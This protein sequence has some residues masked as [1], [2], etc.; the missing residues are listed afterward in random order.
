MSAPYRNML[1]LL[2]QLVACPN[3]ETFLSTAL[4]GF[5]QLVP[6][7]QAGSAFLRDEQGFRFVAFR[8]YNFS[9]TS[10]V[11]YSLEKQL[12][13]YGGSLDEALQGIA[14]TSAVKVEM[15]EILADPRNNRPIQWAMTLPIPFDGRIEAWLHL[16]RFEPEPF[17]EESHELAQ[18][19]AQS[20]EVVLRALRERE[21]TQAR[22]ERE[23]MMAQILADMTGYA[24]ELEVWQHLPNLVAKLTKTERVFALKRD[25]N[26]L[27]LLS[28]VGLS[29]ALAERIPRGSGIS[30][31][32]VETKQVHFTSLDDPEIWVLPGFIPDAKAFGAFV[33]IYDQDNEAQGSLNIFSHVAF[34][35]EDKSLLEVLGHTIGQAL[36]R[37]KTQEREVERLEKLSRAGE[38]LTLAQTTD[39]LLQT[40]V[41]E[42]L[43]QTRASCC[44]LLLHRDRQLE[45][46]G[47]KGGQAAQL[48][49]HRVVAG[50]GL[51]W[52]VFESGKALHLADASQKPEAIYSGP[53]L[54][55][56][57]LGVPLFGPEGERLGVLSVDTS[58]GGGEIAPQDRYTLEA[59][60]KLAGIALSRLQAISHA[61]RQTDNYRALV[62]MSS[63]LEL[64]T[65]PME[66]ASKSL[67]SL[68]GLLDLDA[69]ALYQLRGMPGREYLEVAEFFPSPSPFDVSV[70]SRLPL[71]EGSN[72][73]RRML[74]ERKVVVIEDYASWSAALPGLVDIGLGTLLAFPLWRNER[75]DGMLALA[76]FNRTIEVSEESK[77]LLEAVTRRLERALERVQH[78]QEI[79]HSR[80][81]ALRT[82]GLGLEARDFE[83]KGHTDRVVDLVAELGQRL[84]F[85]DIEGLR[86]GA[87]L[88]DLGKMAISDN[89]LL[90]PGPLSPE[91]WEI[92]KRH[93]DL[94]AQMIE[95]FVFLPQTAHNIVRFHHERLDGSGYPLGLSYEAI[96]L[97]ARIFAVV[98]VFDALM[99]A[100]PYK[101]AWTLKETHQELRRQA[102]FTLDPDV[103]EAMLGLTEQPEMVMG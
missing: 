86:M 98:D 41:E 16:D 90:K 83:T 36:S 38:R 99:H 95:E 70:L 8:N 103:V 81:D 63:E 64:I 53:R 3:M 94:G 56:A 87:Y 18:E 92:M 51:S 62:Q 52:Q 67:Q 34:S 13:W 57:Y 65:D 20:L 35:L 10:T 77:A 47:A 101:R 23:A 29:E 32:A 61:Y 93:C 6:D 17:P 74:N 85:T 58:E 5:V 48:V 45:V 100:R 39:E 50:Q 22:L 19:L 49:G 79:F 80:E 7:A 26:D 4:D 97:E 71:D 69:G 31:K 33:P 78:L 54:P 42:A 82:L 24:S 44:V 11:R 25:S 12:R 27:V 43:E 89:I 91:E 68:M 30:W 76:T 37:L 1:I 96:P 28:S 88:H 21:R 46:V 60:A 15:G 75:L 2:R 55:V 102:G 72:L 9:D 14:K 59:L 66:L 84:G 40:V 73:L